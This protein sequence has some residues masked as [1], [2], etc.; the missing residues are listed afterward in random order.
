MDVLLVT[1][2]TVGNILPL[3]TIARELRTRGHEVSFAG[4][5]QLEPLARGSGFEF[6]G[7]LDPGPLVELIRQKSSKR[8]C[9]VLAHCRASGARFAAEELGAPFATFYLS[10]EVLNTCD[11]DG[12]GLALFPEWFCERRKCWPTQVV[13][14]GFVSFDEPLGRLSSA[15][16]DDFLQRGEPPLV[17]TRG[18]DA[19]QGANFFRESLAT[20]ASLGTRAVLITPHADQ[21]P[22]DLPSWAL[23][24]DYIPLQKIL[25]HASALI[26]HGGIGTC[27]QAI[28]AGVPQLIAPIKSDQFDNAHHIEALGVGVSVPMTDYRERNVARKLTQ[29]LDAVY[30][31]RTC[32]MW[33]T[34]FA[35]DN[36]V[37]AACKAIENL[38][39][40]SNSRPQ[41]QR[42]PLLAS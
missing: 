31:K 15:R 34:T 8:P 10:P 22:D 27:A 14:T 42:L 35:E 2:G 26:Y 13:T 11:A 1:L 32:G 18:T 37:G 41:L 19:L 29:L 9:L 7:A 20:C 16:I 36:A 38:A 39:G 4:N 33:A 23:Q 6:N 3:L 25:R 12:P 21:L 28:R 17:F 30:I 5:S 24:V 40:S